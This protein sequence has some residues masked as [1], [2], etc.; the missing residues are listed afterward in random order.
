MQVDPLQCTWFHF[1][2]LGVTISQCVILKWKSSGILTALRS[3]IIDWGGDS[4][5]ISLKASKQLLTIYTG[6][7]IF[8]VSLYYLRHKMREYLMTAFCEISVCHS[9]S[10]NFLEVPLFVPLESPNII[11]NQPLIH[12]LSQERVTKCLQHKLLHVLDIWTIVFPLHEML[13]LTLFSWPPRTQ[14]NKHL[15]KDGFIKISDISSF[16]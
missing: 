6:T 12:L 5:K 8:S 15:W 14:F 2:T 13:F 7:W 10:F 11:C 3:L 4:S 9:I 1:L 16:L